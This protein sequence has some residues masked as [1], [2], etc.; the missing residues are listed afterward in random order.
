[1]TEIHRRSCADYV[2][3]LF[4]CS[5]S[6]PTTLIALQSSIVLRC[7]YLTDAENAEKAAL[8]TSI[9]GCAVLQAAAAVLVLL[10]PSRRR[11]IRYGIA[12]VALAAAIVG[13]CLYATAVR[14]VLKADP[15]YLFYRIFC[16]VTICIFAVGDL[17]S[18]IK[19]LLGRAEQKE[20]DEEE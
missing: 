7:V 9:L 17:F 2:R 3:F 4:L 5:C 19:L 8:W 1:M 13:H 20:E 18:F 14:L 10:V 6:D 11:R 15:G 16:T 12:I